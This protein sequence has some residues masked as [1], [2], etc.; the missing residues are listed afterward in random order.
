M[1]NGYGRP[2][3]I[4]RLGKVALVG[5]ALAA[6]A[7]LAGCERA[8]SGHADVDAVGTVGLELTVAPGVTL[9]SVTYT[10]TG[11]GFTKTG[12]IDTSGAPTVNG[13]IGGIPAG[14]G[15]TITLAATSAEGGTTFTGSATFDVTAGATTAITIRLNGS[16]KTGNGSVSVNGTINVSP[17]LDEVTVTPQTAFVGSAIS[18]L[19]VA[20]D[21]DAL[22]SPLSYYWSTTGGVIDFPIS[23]SATLTSATP[24]TFTIT[25]TVSDG[26]ATDTATTTVTFVR[27]PAGADGGAGGTGG[28]VASRPNILLII[29]D[30]LG[31]ESTSLYPALA[32]TQGQVSIP[33]IE[34]LAQTGVVFDNAWASPVCSPTRGTIVS[35]QYGFRTGVTTV[36]NVLPTSTVTLFDRLTAESPSYAHAFFGKYHLG[37]GNPGIDPRAP[38]VL[39]DTARVLQ[40]VRD[41]GITTY[42]GI[43]TGAI[44]DYYNWVSYDING[45]QVTNTTYST[46]VLADYAIDFIR[47]QKATRPGQPWFLYQAFN[48]PHAAN[49]GNNPYQVPPANLHH[50]DLSAVGNP[51]PGV[52]Q[53]NIPV[54][55]AD[56]QALDTEIG[57]LLAEVDLSTTL[58]IFVGDNG[59]PPPVKDTATGLRDAKGSAYEGGVR[60]PLFVAGAGVTRRGREDDLFVTTDLYATI[61]DA[62][63]VPV[64]HVND[65]YSIKPLFTDEA[66]SSGRTHSFSEVSSGTAQRRYGLR[67]TRFKLD[68]DLGQWGLYDLATDPKEATNLFAN[69]QYAAVRAALLAEVATLKAGAAPGY[70]VLP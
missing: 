23:P 60:V 32:G 37:G 34:A 18:L 50:V 31:A 12:A 19:A 8:P 35:G 63:G 45:P 10:I 44:V 61:L 30:D 26:A 9:N 70:F 3:L 27:P 51:A 43:L 62:A 29:A 52:Y 17:R 20:R 46:T 36:G 16:S 6:S 67:D 40:H 24:G 5:L 13:T 4:A 11:N 47:Q 21:P 15:Y 38:A 58:V 42:R 25:L 39:T 56:I 66:A 2:G 53:T 28:G 48:A 33:N 65:S 55:Q 68:N 59:V 22:P 64:S 54:Y 57:R 41:L 1:T 7:P 14:K 49:G 69:P